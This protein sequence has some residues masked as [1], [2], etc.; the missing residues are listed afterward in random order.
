MKKNKLPIYF[1]FIAVF[2]FITIFST[3]VQ[4]SYFN[5]INPIKEVE[6]NK[7]L[8]PIDPNLDIQVIEKIKNRPEIINIG[9]IN[10]SIGET[11]ITIA[12]ASSEQNSDE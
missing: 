7:L 2:S 12:T 6:S 1:I 9:D 5:L 8:T 11:S 3:I 10:F 4:K